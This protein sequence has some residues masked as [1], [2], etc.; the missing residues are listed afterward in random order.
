MQQ[1]SS[2]TTASQMEALAVPPLPEAPASVNVHLTLS[3]RQVQLT[4]RDSDE[5]RLL[6]RLEAVLQRFPGHPAEA[7]SPST[8]QGKGWCKI[9]KTPMRQNTKNGRAWYSHK[10]SNDQWCKGR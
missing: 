10:F 8:E 7:S 4:L 6:V 3:G 5:S 1:Q 2:A 9:H